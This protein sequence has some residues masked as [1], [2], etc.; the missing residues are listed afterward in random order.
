M[1][2]AF[3]VAVLP[4]VLAGG[5][6]SLAFEALLLPR[7]RA[8]WRREWGANAIHVGLWLL[9][10]ALVI[11][12]W[13]RP[14]F[15][16]FNALALELLL[17]LVSRAKF[18]A[19]R[20]PF[21]VQDFE[22]F[23]DAVRHPRLYVPFLGV[24]GCVAA[25]LAYAAAVWVGTALEPSLLRTVPAASFLGGVGALAFAGLA[26]LWIGA[27]GVVAPTWDPANDLQRLGFAAHLW[28][29]GRAL[30]RER[31][32]RP[33]AM[34]LALPPRP[35]GAP[36]P[37]VVVVQS[38][39]FFDPRALHPGIR[40][41]VLREVDAIRA[42]ACSHGA[43]GVPAWGAN[44]VRTEFAFLAGLGPEA[45][46]VH[47]FNPYRHVARG[48]VPTVA[49]FLKGL[50]YRTV[51]V[52]PYP[53]SF[54]G[55]DEV[56]PLL[57]FDAFIDRSAFSAADLQGPYVGDEAVAR[58]VGELLEGS[59]QPLFVFVIT[60]ENHGPLHLES[61]APGDVERLYDK[62]PVAGSEELTIYLRHLANA[63]RMA[64]TLREQLSRRPDGGCLCWYG[65]HV[66]IMP[67]AY[68]VLGEPSGK[69]EYFIWRSDAPAGERRDLE[70]EQLGVTLLQALGLVRK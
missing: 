38:E 37:A 70:V 5:A 17:V 66:P 34:P 10:C 59:A 7:P 46:G 50:G 63:D 24:A 1:D 44:T 15:A 25:A 60:M 31:D 30:R 20:E 27:R 16:V 58:K 4:A 21:L 57:G 28:L 22:Y 54:Y 56:Y 29:Y 48:G 64:G 8:P 42:A 62:A 14:V 49:S 3:W 33:A 36:L 13:R 11:L 52:H 55:R 18:R 41:E 47:R 35:V 23:I 19:L 67:R 45:L 68:A 26:L 40:R 32:A 65:D 9:L 53:A 43:L 51:C 2:S 6:L 69:T 12:V 61:V 39:S